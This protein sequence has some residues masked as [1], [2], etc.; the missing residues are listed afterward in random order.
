M[1]FLAA[2]IVLFIG[3]T[4]DL[5]IQ[6]TASSASAASPATQTVA[7]SG[8]HRGVVGTTKRPDPFV[9]SHGVVHAATPAATTLH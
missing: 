5:A 3:V 1:K 4:G 9:W 7:F 2:A 8:V 6:S